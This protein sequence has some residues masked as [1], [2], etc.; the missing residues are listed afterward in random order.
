MY[1][2]NMLKHEQ[3]TEISKERKKTCENLLLSIDR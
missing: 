3:D 1:N 2:W